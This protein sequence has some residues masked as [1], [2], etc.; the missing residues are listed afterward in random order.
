MRRKTFKFVYVRIVFNSITL[1]IIDQSH[2][3]SPSIEEVVFVC[4]CPTV[5]FAKGYFFLLAFPGFMSQ[6]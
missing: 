1:M 4:Q 3:H 6:Q 5:C 2:G